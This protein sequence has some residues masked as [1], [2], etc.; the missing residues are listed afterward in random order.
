[1]FKYTYIFIYVYTQPF[2]EQAIGPLCTIFC[3]SRIPGN[4]LRLSIQNDLLKGSLPLLF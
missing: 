1:M 4:Y 3:I 2:R